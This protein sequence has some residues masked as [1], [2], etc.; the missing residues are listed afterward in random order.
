MTGSPGFSRLAACRGRASCRERLLRL[1]PGLPSA[2]V[3]VNHSTFRLFRP[4]LTRNNKPPLF[5]EPGQARQDILLI[6]NSARFTLAL[7]GQCRF[8]GV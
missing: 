6:Y 7:V 4:S 2:D 8:D 1:K 3:R 5:L